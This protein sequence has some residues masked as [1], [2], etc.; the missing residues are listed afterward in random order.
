MKQPF[1]R[2]LNRLALLEVSLVPIA[3]IGPTE[4]VEPLMIAFH[5]GSLVWV[6]AWLMGHRY[7]A[8]S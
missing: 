4:A 8:T 1:R 2:F 7:S 6:I 5:I 3:M